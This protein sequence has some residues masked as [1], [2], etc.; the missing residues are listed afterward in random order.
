MKRNELLRN[1]QQHK[2]YEG[3]TQKEIGTQLGTINNLRIELNKLNTKEQKKSTK[4]EMIFQK[5]VINRDTIYMKYYYEHYFDPQLIEKYVL[6][7]VTKL[8]DIKKIHTDVIPVFNLLFSRVNS[9][10]HDY[11]Q[12]LFDKKFNTLNPEDANKAKLNYLINDILE[13][14]MH[15]ARDG[16]YDIIDG[17]MIWFVVM[18]DQLFNSYLYTHFIK[19]KPH[20]PYFIKK[21]INK[22]QM[23]ALD[24]LV[25]GLVKSCRNSAK[26]NSKNRQII[27][28]NF[29]KSDVKV[30]DLMYVY[31]ELINLSDEYILEN[32]ELNDFKLVL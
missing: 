10:P 28:D 12:E 17:Y 29:N 22:I 6:D 16:G 20:T 2:K 26:T 19:L 21:G 7:A 15:G 24:G 27:Y 8:E 13:L 9:R 5:E 1:L 4:K 14:A 18:H 23:P 3:L 30:L 25:E 31:N 32:I 11:L